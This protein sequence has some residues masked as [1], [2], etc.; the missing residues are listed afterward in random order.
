MMELGNKTDLY[1]KKLSTFINNSDIDKLF[2]IGNKALKTY[3]ST[4]KIKRGN[5]LQ[6]LQDFDEVFSNV[7]KKND[8][9]MIKGSNST[10]LNK[11]SNR[12]IKGALNVI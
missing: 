2:I 1:H 12:I 4:N 10:G 11:L 6:S 7:I 5:I 9:L 8:Y 3:Q